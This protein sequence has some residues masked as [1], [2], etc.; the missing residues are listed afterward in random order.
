[1]PGV[2]R[3]LSSALLILLG[4]LSAGPAAAAT[5]PTLGQLEALAVE[6]AK[7]DDETVSPLDELASGDETVAAL[8]LDF[9]RS[10]FQD[11]ASRRSTEDWLGK[12]PEGFDLYSEWVRRY[13]ETMAAAVRHLSNED[14]EFVFSRFLQPMASAGESRCAALADP[15]QQA[16]QIRDIL[17]L[18]R[19]DSLDYY[20]ML[21]RIFQAATTNRVPP[22]APST[23]E[24]MAARLELMA[25]LPESSR[26]GL[27]SA[28]RAREE[29]TGASSCVFL[30]RTVSAMKAMPGTTGQLVRREFVAGM[31]SPP[32][33]EGMS[34]R[35]GTSVKGAASGYFEPG[36]VSLEYPV[37]AARAGIE[38]SM[39][40]R[41][42]VGSDGRATR[43]QT[44]KRSFNMPAAKLDDGTEIPVEEMFDPVV[45][46]FYKAGRFM[47]R[48]KD[49]VPQ[50]YVV[51]V[52]LDWKLQ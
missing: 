11:P 23:E 16:A 34:R 49:G 15:G 43:V 48:F 40:V 47:R 44:V 7:D 32:S 37:H 13:R 5:R 31:L 18:T 6:R 12:L 30:I 33:P 19:Q 51:E 4:A 36:N 52:P 24:I 14:V 28:A 10:L 17:G 45:S 41:I 9:L 29:P 42:W 22:K 21:S 3:L 26:Q 27:L 1:M 8:R 46:V 35:L 2:S 50:A 39:T 38:G 20:S 25:S